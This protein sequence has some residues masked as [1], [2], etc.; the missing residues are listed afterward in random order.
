MACSAPGSNAR[1][2]SSE[3]L[4]EFVDSIPAA[5]DPTGDIDLAG[6]T[7]NAPDATPLAAPLRPGIVRAFGLARPGRVIA[8]CASPRSVPGGI[9]CIS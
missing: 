6:E 1:A 9:S 4:D 8:A 3:S 5:F 2:A 7:R